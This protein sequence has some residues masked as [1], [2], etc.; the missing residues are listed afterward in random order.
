MLGGIYEVGALRALEEAID[1]LDLN[2]LDVYVGVSAGAF[3]GAHL[4][5]GI[6]VTE[7]LRGLRAD[8]ADGWQ[9]KV[10]DPAI[11]YVPAFREVGRLGLQLPW[12]V[13]EVLAQLLAG[14]EHS[15]LAGSIEGLGAMLPLSLF[16]NEAIR[17]YLHKLFTRPG[18]TDD[19]RELPRQLLVMAT[20]IDTG[21]AVVFGRR[22]LD[23]VPISRAVQASTA[24]PGLYQPVEVE[25]FCCVDGVLLKT[26]HATVAL[27]QGA[28]LL[29]AVNPLVPWNTD[30]ADPQEAMGRK[31]IL[32]SGLPALLSQCFRILIHSR[33]AMG[34]ER[35]ARNYPNADLVLFEPESTEHRLFTNLFRFHSRRQVCAIGYEQTR[36]SLWSRRRTLGPILE[37]HGLAL[38]LEVLADPY[39]SVWD[40]LGP[41]RRE[42]RSVAEQLDAA[43]RSLEA[44][45]S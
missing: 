12:T 13:T 27:G 16:D 9:A 44:R 3:V 43:L 30:T 20:D 41:S 23:H 29:F 22:G 24:V 38:R 37:K 17:D 39:R 26:M 33:V 8:P 10:F 6:T 5:N 18:M 40:C 28:D 45:F 19:F 42:N 32:R 14:A 21:G 34:I 35:A 7:L 15:S 2:R 4:V 1:G 11:F 36:K 31:A 25:G